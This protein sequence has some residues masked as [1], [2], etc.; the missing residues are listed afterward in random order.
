M[1]IPVGKHWKVLTIICHQHC[2]VQSET[3]SLQSKNI[4]K[5]E[6]ARQSGM[7]KVP[8]WER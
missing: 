6:L 8:A 2:R 7:A 3:K 5:K 4:K 1:F